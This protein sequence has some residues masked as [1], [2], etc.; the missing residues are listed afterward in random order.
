MTRRALGRG[1]SALLTDE[2][3]KDETKEELFEIPIFKQAIKTN[4]YK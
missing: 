3:P 4:G 2:S 1:L